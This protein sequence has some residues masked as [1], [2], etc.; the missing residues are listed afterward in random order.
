MVGLNYN[1]TTIKM[2]L[3]ATHGAE[4]YQGGSEKSVVNVRSTEN[5]WLNSL[6]AQAQALVICKIVHFSEHCTHCS[7]VQCSS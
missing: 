1:E 3:L 2:T 6:K 4:L 5:E 7:I